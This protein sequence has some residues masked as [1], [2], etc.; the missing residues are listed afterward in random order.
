MKLHNTISCSL[1]LMAASL[2]ANAGTVSYS[3]QVDTSGIAGVAPAGGWLDFQFNQANA[4]DSL[5][6]LAVIDNF[7]S[8]GFVFGGTQLTSSGVTGALPGPVTIPNDQGGANYFTQRVSTWGSGFQFA[9]TLS[10]TAV[11][12]PAPDGSTFFLFLLFPDFNQ[13]VAPPTIAGEIL[14]VNIDT[15]GATSAQGST[16]D[17]G[18]A[19][20]TP[21]PGAMWLAL[22]G[23]AVVGARIR[24][25]RKL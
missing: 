2:G 8:T 16:F 17:G 24:L 15:T 10:G 21:E 20:P 22:A 11:G 7:S 13:I 18:S 9:V 19:L 25:G 3:F 5:S 1:V 14:N 12:T 23:L 6:A 4:L